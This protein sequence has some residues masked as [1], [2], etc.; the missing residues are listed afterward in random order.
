MTRLRLLLPAALLVLLCAPARAAY[1][2]GQAASYVLGQPDFSHVDGNNASVHVSSGFNSPYG[3]WIS[4]TLG[5]T[6]VSDQGN[7][8]VLIYN[9]TYPA[10]GAVPAVVLG[11]PNLTNNAANDNGSNIT[12]SASPSNLN[13]PR[14]VY[15]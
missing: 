11:H 5:K 3:V 14:G 1:T 4:T 12:G 7:H 13:N 6:F 2:T 8:R 10:P 9:S 15:V